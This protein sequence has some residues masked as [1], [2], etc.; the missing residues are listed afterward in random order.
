[1]STASQWSCDADAVV[2]GGIILGGRSKPGW[3][4]GRTGRSARVA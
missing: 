2:A 1:M 3:S 4:A